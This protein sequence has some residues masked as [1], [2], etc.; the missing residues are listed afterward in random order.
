MWALTADGFCIV[1]LM[2][3][4]HSV[5]RK[6]NNGT[7]M[8]LVWLLI[9]FSSISM[10]YMIV[11][12]VDCMNKLAEGNALLG[13][14]EMF[15]LSCMLTIVGCYIKVSLTHSRTFLCTNRNNKKWIRKTK[16]SEEKIWQ[17][18]ML[19]IENILGRKLRKEWS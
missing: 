8:G 15:K 11:V 5:S 13:R 1:F 10:N 4:T 12:L 7:W 19:V 9:F 18:I 6:G 16:G 2:V 14:R 3:P 17:N